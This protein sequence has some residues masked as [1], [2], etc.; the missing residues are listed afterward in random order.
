MDIYMS[1]I[2]HYN[3]RLCM[4]CFTEAFRAPIFR[5]GPDKNGFSLGRYNNFLEVFGSN[6][7]T[8][9]LPVYTR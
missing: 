9:F 8:W 6:P 7:K 1:F 4:Y 5:S 2:H 3:V